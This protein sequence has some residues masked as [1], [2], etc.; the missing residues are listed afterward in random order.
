MHNVTKRPCTQKNSGS[1]VR[2]SYL[3]TSRTE[4]YCI[5]FFFLPK[6]YVLNNN[7]LKLQLC[8]YCTVQMLVMLIHYSPPTLLTCI[9]PPPILGEFPCM[10]YHLKQYCRNGENCKFSH[11]PLNADTEALLATVSA[12][13]VQLL[14]IIIIPL[15]VSHIYTCNYCNAT[16][17]KQFYSNISASTL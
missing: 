14:I 6:H 16:D 5:P 1:A 3:Q 9:I 15:S 7:A 11:A 2:F 13:H 12:A 8:I 17:T 4:A 10:F